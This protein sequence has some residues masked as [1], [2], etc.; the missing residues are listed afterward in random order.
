VECGKNDLPVPHLAHL[1]HLETDG[2]A[3]LYQHR[4]E[5]ESKSEL[6]RMKV[7]DPQLVGR[8][9]VS[10]AVLLTKNEESTSLTGSLEIYAARI[11]D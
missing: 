8:E 3:A 9:P 6:M 5:R 11:C 4:F 7:I 2:T 10:N 1:K